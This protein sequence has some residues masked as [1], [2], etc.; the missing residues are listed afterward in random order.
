MDLIGLMLLL[1]LGK[2]VA[3]AQFSR[4]PTAIE[5]GNLKTPVA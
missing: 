1:L 5:S 3:G 2:K 4:R